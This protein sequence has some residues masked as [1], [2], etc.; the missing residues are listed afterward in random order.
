MTRSNSGL[1]DEAGNAA[2]AYSSALDRLDEPAFGDAQ[3]GQRDPS[4]Q[5]PRRPD[6]LTEPDGLFDDLLGLQE[7][8]PLVEH[9]PPGDQRAEG[10]RM[11]EHVVV[12]RPIE[13]L[14][15]DLLGLTELSLDT[16]GPRE[17]RF[18]RHLFDNE[19]EI[20]TFDCGVV[21]QA[22]TGGIIEPEPGEHGQLHRSGDDRI[23]HPSGERLEKRGLARGCVATQQRGDS[24][25]AGQPSDVPHRQRTGR[26]VDARDPTLGRVCRSGDH[27]RHRDVDRPTGIVHRT[28]KIDHRDDAVEGR[29]PT[30]QEHVVGAVAEERVRGLAVARRG[31]V[32]DRAVELTGGRVPLG[33]DFVQHRKALR[34]VRPQ[35]VLQ[36]VAEELVVVVRVAVT[37]RH[38]ERVLRRQV[39]DE[40]R[41]LGDAGDRPARGEVEILEHR[42]VFEKP[43]DVRWLPVQHLTQQEL[44]H[45]AVLARELL[46]ERPRIGTTA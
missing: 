41:A 40:I 1:G 36:E 22:R 27:Q 16:R 12:L 28:L 37:A 31:Q 24:S 43:L 2:R 14:E 8:V 42:A 34:G 30:V 7:S 13:R 10:H 19:L 11:L 46:E 20:G 21:Q 29:R 15:G 38:D 25:G 4:E 17:R 32:P 44:R 26:L 45:Q 18:E 9:Q 6:A 33:R 3:T 39:P 5:H 23:L 35:A